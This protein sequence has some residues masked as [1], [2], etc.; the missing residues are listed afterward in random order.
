MRKL[1]FIFIFMAARNKKI[2]SLVKAATR[3]IEEAEWGRLHVLADT[4]TGQLKE[5]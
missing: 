4:Y 5:K 1:L 3:K 2:D